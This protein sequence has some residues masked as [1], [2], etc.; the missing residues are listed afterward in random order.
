MHP[1]N[2]ATAEAVREAI[3]QADRTEK[4]VAEGARISASTWQRRIHARTAFTNNELSRIATVLGVK[5]AGLFAAI[6]EKL[7]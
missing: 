3:A 5:V 1:V 4:S 7:R 6:E 2:T